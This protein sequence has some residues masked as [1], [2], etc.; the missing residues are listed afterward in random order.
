VL[1]AKK[2]DDVVY[3]IEDTSICIIVNK[4]GRRDVSAQRSRANDG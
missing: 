1:L 4:K 3:S 2:Y